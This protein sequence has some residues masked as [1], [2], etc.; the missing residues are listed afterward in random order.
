MTGVERS[1]GQGMPDSLQVLFIGLRE[2]FTRDVLSLLGD[3]CTHSLTVA[4]EDWQDT[5][6]QASRRPGVAWVVIGPGVEKHSGLGGVLKCTQLCS[7]VYRPQRLVVLVDVFR[8][9]DV[10]RLLRVG[11]DGVMPAGVDAF[12]VVDELC[13]SGLAREEFFPEPQRWLQTLTRAAEEL[14]LSRHPQQTI[15][16]QLRLFISQ[17]EVSRASVSL[18]EDGKLR[19]LAGVGLPPGLNQHQAVAVEPNTISGWVIEHKRARLVHGEF[20]GQS[21]DVR[22]A[23]CAPLL[24]RDE[25]I[26]VVSFES[27]GGAR[28]LTHADLAAAE[29]FAAMLSMAIVNHR[30]VEEG[31]EAERLVTIG[32]TMASVSHCL[33]N[34]LMVLK[35]STALFENAV[36][37]GS[38]EPVEKALPVLRSGI[39]RMEKLVLDLLDYAKRRPPVPEPVKF[40]LFFEEMAATFRQRPSERKQELIMEISPVKEFPVDRLRLERALLN[41]LHNASEAAPEGGTILLEAEEDPRQGMVRI[42]V[43]DSGEGV[44][45]DVGNRIFEPFFSTKGSGGTGLGLPMVKHFCTESGGWVEADACSRLGGLRV[46]MY[47]PLVPQTPEMGVPR[48]NAT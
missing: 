8:L 6:W 31:L 46:S 37:D 26:G 40:P 45:E 20:A 39:T 12:H 10:L 5:A 44:S 7:L 41:L 4:G 25:V 18:R 48:Q 27:L 29:V 43:S 32:T 14:D 11:A 19:I 15:K 47:L 35:G 24:S 9:D 42:S 21:G 16:K 28:E 1:A 3:K 30:L 34:L 22:H 33:K 17:L 13:H 23:I 38:V 36:E 2:E